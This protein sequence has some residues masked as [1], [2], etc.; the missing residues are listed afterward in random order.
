MQISVELLWSAIIT[1]II[2]PMAWV[3][4]YLVKEVKRQQILLNRTREDYAKKSEVKSD[5]E[6]V[7]D[8]LHRLE[9]KLDKVL[10]K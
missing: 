3:F 4:T 9:D 10:S 6:T 2:C 5:I 8:A 1:L 7:M